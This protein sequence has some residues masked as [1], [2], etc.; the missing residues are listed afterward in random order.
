M[1]LI[2]ALQWRY[3]AKRMTG[4]TV[5]ADKIDKILGAAHLSPSGIGLQPYEIIV[6]THP[7]WKEKILPIAMNQPAVVQASHLLIFAAWD[8]YTPERIHGVFDHLNTERAQPGS[9][10][11]SQRNFSLGYFEKLAPETHFHHAAK[12]AHIGLGLA[13]AAAALEGIDTTPM[14]GFH[15]DQLDVLLDLPAR[16][17]KSSMLLALGYRDTANDWNASLKKVRKP[18]A[19]FITEFS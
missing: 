13:I 1:E 9:A 11:D 7:S 3:A 6:V 15:A 19:E 5:P 17:L 10:S 4:A 8:H 2:T 16:G 18:L 14:E 12:Q